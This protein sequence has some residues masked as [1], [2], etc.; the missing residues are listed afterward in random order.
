MMEAGAFVFVVKEKSWSRH[1]R[2]R[3]REVMED[4]NTLQLVGKL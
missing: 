2:W 1:Q 4:D 3:L